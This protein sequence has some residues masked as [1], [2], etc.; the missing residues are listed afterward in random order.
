MVSAV[1]RGSECAIRGHV[2]VRHNGPTHVLAGGPHRFRCHV[3]VVDPIRPGFSH[4]LI[5]LKKVRRLVLSTFIGFGGLITAAL[6]SRFRNS[7]MRFMNPSLAFETS[8]NNALQSDGPTSQAKSMDQNNRKLKQELED[9][10]DTLC[11]HLEET[12]MPGTSGFVRERP[13][14]CQPMSNAELGAATRLRLNC[15]HKAFDRSLICPGCRIPMTDSDANGHLAGCTRIQHNNSAHAHASMKR[16]ILRLCSV[17]GM[18]CDAREPRRYATLSCPQCRDVLNAKE[19]QAH[20]KECPGH[21]TVA[22]LHKK[23]LTMCSVFCFQI[24]EGK[25]IETPLFPRLDSSSQ[26]T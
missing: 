17:I 23:A 26:H 11:K 8:R 12:S 16:A 1:H 18:A 20:A 5:S 7:Q 10:D 24:A 14:F 4:L 22:E 25:K 13:L 21:V 3:A 19:I 15:V 2:V 9:A 6:L